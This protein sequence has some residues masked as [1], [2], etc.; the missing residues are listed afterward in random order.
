MLRTVVWVV[1]LLGTA[2]LAW[3]QPETPPAPEA[4]PPTTFDAF[5]EA[6]QKYD[7]GARAYER[8]D[9]QAA[10]R[11]FEA[12]KAAAPSP[13]FEFNLGRCL[14]RLGRW[15][16]AASAY[17]RFL[18]GKPTVTDAAE[19][20]ER[21]ADLRLRARDA[22]KPAPPPPAPPPPHPRSLRLPALALLGATVALAGAATGVYL[23]E[24]SEY[25]TRRDACQSRCAPESLDGLR[26]RVQVAQATG[27]VLYGLA[28]AALIVDLVLWIADTRQRRPERRNVARAGAF[29]VRF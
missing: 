27:G 22:A 10:L 8:G 26:T 21:I 7:E 13:E 28:G 4:P 9:Y 1:A 14:E 29:G 3:A 23:S 11:S 6:R 2:P 20:R 25:Q 17:E 5:N 12:A 15:E 24:W 19:I 18:V 16:A